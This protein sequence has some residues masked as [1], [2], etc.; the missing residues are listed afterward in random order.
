MLRRNKKSSR[1]IRHVGVLFSLIICTNT[2]AEMLGNQGWYV[3]L[4]IGYAK[5]NQ[6]QPSDAETIIGK[7]GL[8]KT[9]FHFPHGISAGAELG[10]QTGNTM[11]MGISQD[12]LNTLGGLPIQTTL[13]PILDLLGT[14]T[15]KTGKFLFID[16]RVGAAYRSWQINDRETVN[17]LSDIRP[18]LEIGLGSKINQRFNLS[19][20]YQTIFSTPYSFTIDPVE[21][22]AH[23]NN[24]PQQSGVLLI[25]SINI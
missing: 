18:E 16:T 14:L 25:A 3:N 24:I 2:Y 12:Q 10:V 20:L 19:L 21:D 8:G 9:L 15:I 5:I 1:I 23:V 11:R 13:K 22:T 6:I 7:L 4:G 17:N